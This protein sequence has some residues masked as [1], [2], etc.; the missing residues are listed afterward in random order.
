MDIGESEDEYL[1]NIY[2]SNHYPLEQNI[3][4]DASDENSSSSYGSGDSQPD[5]ISQLLSIEELNELLEKK[6]VGD[7]FVMHINAVS[8][9]AHFDDIE[10]L[11]TAKSFAPPDILCVSETRFKNE[12]IDFQT[13]LTA[14]PD[15]NLIYDNSPANAGGAIYIY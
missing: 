7:I 1:T 13:Q 5:Q 9:V 14:L 10:S 12:K 2:Y 11:I 15:Y 4:W 8:L 6:G 3:I